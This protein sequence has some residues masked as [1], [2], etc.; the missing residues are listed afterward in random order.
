MQIESYEQAV[1]HFQKAI[2]LS[3]E[4]TD[5]IASLGHAYAVSNN[6]N[7]AEKILKQLPENTKEE[8]VSSYEISVLFLGLNQRKKAFDWLKKA[9]SEHCQ[10]MVCLRADPRIDSLRSDLRFKKLL[11]RMNLD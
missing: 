11:R 4:S 7:E 10:Y 8:Y 6:K 1:D 9:Y 2:K 3:G 5:M